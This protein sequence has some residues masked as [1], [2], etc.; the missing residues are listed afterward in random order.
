MCT[1]LRKERK[2]NKK[3]NLLWWYIE[4]FRMDNNALVL[5]AG[6]FSVAL[7]CRILR[8]S[9]RRGSKQY[10]MVSIT[11]SLYVACEPQWRI[12]LGMPSSVFLEKRGACERCWTPLVKSCDMALPVPVH[13]INKR[14]F[15]FKCSILFMV[16]YCSILSIS[17]NVPCFKPVL[18]TSVRNL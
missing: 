2:K 15:K 12:R 16:C 13:Y 7:R 17:L 11:P 5:C 9:R 14:G 1:N 6:G 10:T 18:L 8:A 3:R 4:W